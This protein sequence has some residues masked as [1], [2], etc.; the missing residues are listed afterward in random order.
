M[1]RRVLGLRD[2]S[3]WHALRKVDSWR[4]CCLFSTRHQDLLGYEAAIIDPQAFRV[5]GFVFIKLELRSEIRDLGATYLL[6]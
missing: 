6:L 3:R 5:S 2:I 1:G 4:H